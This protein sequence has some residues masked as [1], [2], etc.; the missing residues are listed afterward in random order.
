MSSDRA[1]AEADSWRL[2]K[3]TMAKVDVLNLSGKKVGSMELSDAVF[4]PEQVN[5][6]LLWEAVKHYPRFAA[7]G[8]ARHQE[9][10]AGSRIGQEAVEAEGHGQGARGLGSIAAVAP[11]RHGARTAAAQLR[12]SLSAQEAAGR[13]ALGAGGETGRRQ[14]DRGGFARDQGRQDQAL[15]RGAEQAGA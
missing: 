4:A 9:P 12:V 15:S 3:K 7:P 11:W 8:H 13:T 1:E 2:K 10:Q 14:A 6:A 5:E